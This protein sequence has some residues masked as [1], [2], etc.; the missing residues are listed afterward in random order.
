MIK[1]P[2]PLACQEFANDEDN[3]HHDFKRSHSIRSSQRNMNAGVVPN[4]ARRSTLQL[5]PWTDSHGFPQAFDFGF[6]NLDA[7]LPARAPLEV[8]DC[9]RLTA[10]DKLPAVRACQPL[11]QARDGNPEPLGRLLCGEKIGRHVKRHLGPCIEPVGHR[12]DRFSSTDHMALP[13]GDYDLDVPLCSENE[14][15]AGSRHRTPKH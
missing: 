11:V 12:S 10:D 5:C 13:S 3:V 14:A 4:L 6:L 1:V 8:S 2:E 7:S 9:V 15:S